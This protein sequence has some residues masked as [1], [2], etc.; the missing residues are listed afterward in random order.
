MTR[1]PTPISSDRTQALHFDDSARGCHGEPP[2]RGRYH[3]WRPDQ[4]CSEIAGLLSYSGYVSNDEAN[5]QVLRDGYAHRA[6]ALSGSTGDSSACEGLAARYEKQGDSAS[7]YAV[8]GNAPGCLAGRSHRGR[9][10][11]DNLS[12]PYIDALAAG[13]LESEVGRQDL[14]RICSEFRG[15]R[16]C[17]MAVGWGPITA[18]HAIAAREGEDRAEREADARR[19]AIREALNQADAERIA[20][21]QEQ[22]EEQRRRLRETLRLSERILSEAISP[23]G[24]VTTA[25][26]SGT[27]GE[28]PGSSF[29]YEQGFVVASPGGWQGYCAVRVAYNKRET[30]GMKRAMEEC[31]RQNGGYSCV[32]FYRPSG[33]AEPAC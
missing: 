1:L 18:E 5:T 21:I 8:L 6:C 2:R 11:I 32:E 4:Y 26:T 15:P 14:V 25:P 22:T 9:L 7:A 20:R 29:G 30:G 33:G 27:A 12:M 19:I 23:G 24:T 28:G 17:S 10:C 13:R 16:A 3:D 31:R